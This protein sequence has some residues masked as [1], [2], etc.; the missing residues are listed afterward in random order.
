MCLIDGEQNLLKF[1]NFSSRNRSHCAPD[2]FFQV[3]I[4]VFVDYFYE[5]HPSSLPKDD[6]HMASVLTK[7]QAAEGS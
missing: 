3:V 2:N 5:L 4:S 1:S 7:G 6:N